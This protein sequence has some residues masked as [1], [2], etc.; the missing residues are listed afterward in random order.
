MSRLN[1][2]GALARTFW[3]PALGLTAL[4]GCGEEATAPDG[5]LLLGEWGSETA[6]FIAL[7]SGAE[8]QLGCSVVIIDEPIALIEGQTFAGA[9]RLQTSS[10][11][12][13]E[14]PGIRGTG[15]VSGS[16]VVLS[17]PVGPGGDLTTLELQAG[18]RPVPA[19][20][21]TCPQ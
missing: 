1:R 7:R 19:E 21:P 14:L 8:V 15:N 6:L 16:R 18:I 17:L 11:V 2:A 3:L 20:A 9:G 10:A 12:L 13:G 4:V 5:P